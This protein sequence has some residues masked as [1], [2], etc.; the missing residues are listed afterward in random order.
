MTR[1]LPKR[2]DSAYAD[3][4]GIDWT[5][6]ET[7]LAEALPGAPKTAKERIDAVIGIALATLVL[8]GEMIGG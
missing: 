1:K 3:L 5:K 7:A 8:F 4:C 6:L 2:C